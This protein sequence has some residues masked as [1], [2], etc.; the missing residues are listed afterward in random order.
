[1]RYRASHRRIAAL[2]GGF[3]FL[4]G[5]GAQWLL[6]PSAVGDASRGAPGAQRATRAKPVE[7]VRPASEPASVDDIAGMRSALLLTRERLLRER[8]AWEALHQNLWLH[9]IGATLYTEWNQPTTLRAINWYGF[10]YAPYVPGGLDRAPLDDILQRLR[11]LGINALRIEFANATV[12]SNPIVRA[13]V[14]AN[15]KFRGLHALDVMQR[16]LE[17]AHR[18]GLRVILCNS[19]SE[20]GMGPELRTGLWYTRRFPESVWRND[21]ITLVTRFRND[22]AFVGADLRNEPHVSGPTMDL[23]VPGGQA[24]DQ[25][26]Y[27]QN[28]P[29]WGAYKGTYYHARDWHYAAQTLGNTLL[30]IN[31]NL[32]IVVEGVQLYLD[33]MRNLLFGGLWGSDLIGVQY[34]PI[35]LDRPSQLVYSAH[36]YGPHMY[37]ARWFNRHTSYESLSRR[38][39][40]HWGYLL[41]APRFMRAPVLIG[42]VGT[43]NNYYAC[44]AS[45]R[46]WRQG[47]WWQSFVRYLRQHPQVSWA[48]WSL[49]PV[50]PFYSGQDNFY[51]LFTRDWR[52]VHPM[53]LLG[54][55][56]LLDEPQPRGDG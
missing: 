19:R 22:S 35:V 7:A 51:S 12:E 13:G 32:L 37:P 26:A 47:F 49:N 30:K 27:F 18:F 8:R 31:P 41:T 10:E 55:K 33:P 24:F 2:I 17:R 28:G 21:W 1:M 4:S 50:G 42:E 44:I 6:Y 46:P 48:Y 38:W 40:H 14:D 23:Q 52:H 36:E 3:A 16:I 34:D 25:K 5:L 54:L 9:G 15:P 43:C 53:L 29:L 20:F 56:P 39:W 11:S 45:H